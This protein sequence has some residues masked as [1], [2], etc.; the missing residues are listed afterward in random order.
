[1]K[2]Q[3]LEVRDLRVQYGGVVALAELSA[4]VEPGEVLGLIG[5]NGAGKTT[6]VDAIT[7]FSRLAAGTVSLGGR[8]ISSLSPVR[9]ARAGISRSFQSLELFEDATVLENL[10]VA[11]DPRDT[12]SYFRDLVFPVTPDLPGEVVA[13]IKE[14]GLEEDLNRR[15]EDLSYG[16]RRLL[17]LARAVASQPS[18]LLL[19]EPASGL[20]DVESRELATLVRRLAD[21][22]GMAI[23][24]IEHDVAFVMSTCDRIV[25][26]DFGRSISQGSP[27]DVRR[28]PAVVAAYLGTSAS[29]AIDDRPERASKPR[30]LAVV[31]LD[32]AGRPESS[33]GD[34][35]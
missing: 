19:D 6:A 3:A 9:R 4:T 21:E 23:L 20:T 27:E 8:D 34:G 18:V 12:S 30:S 15:V 10:R 2:P 14:F 26:L 22:W 5:P 32:D 24:L 7:G 1:M 17:A 25:V 31:E 35:A 13:A 11:A 29:E 16:K 33:L 28:D